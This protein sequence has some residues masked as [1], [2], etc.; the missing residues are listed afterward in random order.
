MADHITDEELI[1]MVGEVEPTQL[2]R[3]VL[4]E[5]AKLARD[6]VNAGLASHEI[7]VN[8]TMQVKVKRS[9]NPGTLGVCWYGRTPYN[10]DYTGDGI[11]D[12]K[13]YV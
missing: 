11:N 2:G 10:C 8:L 5:I 12:G 9:P 13:W 4:A 1:R 7:K 6:Q 3:D